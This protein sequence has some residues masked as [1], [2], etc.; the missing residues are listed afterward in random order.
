MY[1]KKEHVDRK[2]FISFLYN[3]LKIIV[4]KYSEILDFR[5]EKYITNANKQMMKQVFLPYVIK[6]RVFIYKDK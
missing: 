5:E 6:G 4:K 1:V 3:N 2:S